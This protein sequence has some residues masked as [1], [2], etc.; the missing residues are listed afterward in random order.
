M[1]T[2]EIPRAEWPAF[3]DSFSRQHE[4]WLSTIEVLGPDVGA[5]VET[6]ER[7]LVGITADL[8]GPEDTISIMIGAEA[9]EHV[10]HVIRA[11]SSVQLKETPEGAHEALHID[12][13]S[14]PATLLRFRA[15]VSTALLDGY[16]AHP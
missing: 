12:S 3:F 8:K 1:A 15:T 2:R 13:R 4:G 10:D 11:P 16:V 14:G 9:D 7:P 6:R 5:Q